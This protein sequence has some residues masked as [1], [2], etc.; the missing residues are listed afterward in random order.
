MSS[1]RPG[2][3]ARERSSYGRPNT[4]S[5]IESM[6][7]AMSFSM[8]ISRGSPEVSSGRLKRSGRPMAWAGRWEARQAVALVT[9]LAVRTGSSLR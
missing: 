7:Q 5:T 4:K 9:R 2:S 3:A 6:R 1:A 8:T